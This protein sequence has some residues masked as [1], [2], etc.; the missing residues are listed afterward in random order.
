MNVRHEVDGTMIQGSCLCGAVAYAVTGPVG[1][2]VYCHCS[3]CRKATGSGHAANLYAP[4][5]AFR[6]LRGEAQVTRFDLPGARSFST[7]FCGTCGTPLPHATRS[8]REM[9]IPAG[10]LDADPGERPAINAHWDSRAPWALPAA[11]L[12]EPG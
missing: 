11:D 6:W 12:P 10:S 2:F 8:G 7:S 9:I 3:R 5:A 4:P 1:R